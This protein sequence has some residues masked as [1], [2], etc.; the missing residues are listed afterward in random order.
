MTP[1]AVIAPN[2]LT[3]SIFDRSKD[4]NPMLVV[5]DVRKMAVPIFSMV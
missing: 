1:A 3:M 2:C 4:P 5:M